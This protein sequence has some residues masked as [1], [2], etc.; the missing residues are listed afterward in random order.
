[1]KYLGVQ[2]CNTDFSEAGVELSQC[3]RYVSLHQKLLCSDDVTEVSSISKCMFPLINQ[4]SQLS[5]LPIDSQK[6][7]QKWI[8]I[9]FC[10][11]VV[12][13]TTGKKNQLNCQLVVILKYFARVLVDVP[14]QRAVSCD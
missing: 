4:H 8:L 5:W 1:M 2:V 11:A 9:P 12:L 14:H 3:W 6:K 13:M 10:K 7:L